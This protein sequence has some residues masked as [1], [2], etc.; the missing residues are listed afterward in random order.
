MLARKLNDTASACDTSFGTT[1]DDLEVQKPSQDEPDPAEAREQY[2]A[3][4][5]GPATLLS[6]EDVPHPK[7]FPVS[8]VA[9]WQAT[10]VPPPKFAVL[11][12]WEGTVREVRDDSLVVLLRDQ[13]DDPQ[14]DEEAE[15]YFDEIDPEDHDLV[16]PGAIFYWS[17]G[18]RDGR[19]GRERVS[20]IHFRR[21]PVYTDADRERARAAAKETADKLGWG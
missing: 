18:Y 1:L 13:S 21:L 8:T 15:V 9:R 12:A 19:S 17:I 20:L 6:L 10:L 14:P 16:A 7:V 2:P 3:D 5:P 4:Q 11:Q